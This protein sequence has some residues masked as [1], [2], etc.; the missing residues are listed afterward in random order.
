[1]F[2]IFKRIM[3]KQPDTKAAVVDDGDRPLVAQTR[4]W[5]HDMY[6]TVTVH[7]NILVA[8]N[9]LMMLGL[10]SAAF[11]IRFVLSQRT[12]EPFVVQVEEASGMVSVVNPVNADGQNIIAAN[13]SVQSYFVVQYVRARETYS[14]ADYEY[15]YNKLVPLMSNGTVLAAFRSM[16]SDKQTS[17]MTIYGSTRSTSM[18][19]RSLQFLEAGAVAQI[20]FSI[21][22]EGAGAAATPRHRIA[23]L[24]YG[25]VPMRLTPEE[26][27][28]NPLGFVVTSYRVDDETL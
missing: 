18:K 21:F 9:V 22:E 3:A 27:Y 24:R 2:G 14:Y 11:A 19:V 7:R 23:T 12:I 17:P 4:N 1:M 26:R 20:R 6:H 16:V 13:E 25:F 10:I 28:V 8:L 5:Y 15:A